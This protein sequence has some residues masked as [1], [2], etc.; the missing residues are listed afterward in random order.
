MDEAVTLAEERPAQRYARALVVFNAKAGSVR[1][2][3]AERL[4]EA[5]TAAG[6]EQ[7]AMVGPEKLTRKLL[8]RA[9]DFDVIIVLGGDGTACAAASKAPR[10]GPP[11][12]LLPGG[13]M[14]M[15]PHAL[16]GELAWPEALAAALERGVVRRLP[17]GYANN[18]AFFVAAMFGAPTLLA[19]AREAAREGKLLTAFRRFRLTL[20]RAFSRSVFARPRGVRTQKSAAVG[21]L[22]PIFSGAV[23]GDALEWVNVDARQL[24]EIA[25]LTVRAVTPAWRDDPAV[26]IYRCTSGRVFSGG[27]IPSTLDGEPKAFLSY[28]R[29]RYEPNGPRVLALETEA[30]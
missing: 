6:V 8:E 7:Y 30:S 13:T 22:C 28:V 26:E 17:I 9:K 2:G 4:A 5:L 23:E 16:Y 20:S 10:N 14:N 19:R 18:E 11:L 27:V 25:R 24:G 29:I 15:L 3:D 1:D 12:V 21:V